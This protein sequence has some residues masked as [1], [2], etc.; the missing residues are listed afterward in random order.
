MKVVKRKEREGD[1]EVMTA[2]TAAPCLCFIFTAFSA[3]FERKVKAGARKRSL[4][5]DMRLCD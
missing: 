2:G 3:S 5:P 4:D 1:P